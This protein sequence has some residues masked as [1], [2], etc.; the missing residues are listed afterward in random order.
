MNRRISIIAALAVAALASTARTAAAQ[1]DHAGHPHLNISD[2]WKECSIQLSPGL[3]Q[4]AWRQFTREAGVVAYFRPLADARPMG[5]GNFEVSLHQ[6]ETGIDDHDDAWNNTFV[7]PDSTH[8]L[9]EGN[10]LKFPGLMV[11]G[12]LTDRTDA[13]IYFTKNPNANYGFIGAQVQQSLAPDTWDNWN[14]AARVSF[15]TLYGPEDVDHTVYGVDLV[16][17]RQFPVFSGRAVISPYAGVSATLARSKEKSAVVQLDDES[18]AGTQ[19]MV[20]AAAR[21]YNA[22]VSVEYAVATVPSLSLKI[23]VGR[24]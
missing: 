8:Y 11:R 23:G 15:V 16:A 7:H 20:G 24:N 13:G 3:T 4:S 9:F 10:G 18:V 2:R 17:S 12:G 1:H 5:R 14:A 21:I 22:T 19:G 6:W